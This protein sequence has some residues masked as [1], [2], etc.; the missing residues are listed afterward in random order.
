MSL[1]G[2]ETVKSIFVPI[3]TYGHEFWVMTE[4]VRSQIY[5]TKIKFL[6]KIKGATMFDKLC[7][8]AIRKSLNLESLLLRIER[9]QLTRFGYVSRMSQER[10]S[11]QTLNGEVIGKR[12]VERLQ[13]RWLDYIEDLGWNRL[14][15]HPN[16][17]PS[18]LV[19][20]EKWRLNLELL[21]W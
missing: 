3:L 21:P 9:S 20:R 12:P 2:L 18:V 10:L 15:L 7:N 11:K 17:L 19:D 1:P 6:R 5:A 14:E 4:R 8:T 16:K 13:T